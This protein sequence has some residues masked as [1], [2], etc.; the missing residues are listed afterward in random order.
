MKENKSIKKIILIGSGALASEVVS[1]IKDINSIQE[2]FKIYG[3]LDDNGLDYFREN[4]TKYRLENEY[5]GTTKNFIFSDDYLYVICFSNITAR[6]DLIDQLKLPTVYY[7][8][9]IHP[10]VQFGSGYTLGDGNIIGPNCVV[11]PASYIGNFNI[12]TSYSYI[13]HDCRVGNNNFLST[14]G[15]AGYVVLGNDNFF[16]IRATVIPSII[17]GNENL[18]QAGMIVD[19]NIQNSEAVFYK[20][21]ERFFVNREI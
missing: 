18:I 14:A 7:P 21:K 8:N 9:I 1:Y 3:F 6:K 12:L 10:S 20:Y 19:S 17:I 2:Q 11:G 4:Q 16:G 5:L 13:S 15:L